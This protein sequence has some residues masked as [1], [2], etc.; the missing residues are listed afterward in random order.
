MTRP[1]PLSAPVRCAVGWGYLPQGQLEDRII[2]E[3]M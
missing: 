1:P 2:G 3:N